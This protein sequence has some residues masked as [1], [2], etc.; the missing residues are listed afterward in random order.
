MKYWDNT[1]PARTL[2]GES[3]SNFAYL[4]PFVKKKGVTISREQQI[5]E[6]VF[7]CVPERKQFVI[8]FSDHSVGFK[9]IQYAVR[10]YISIKQLADDKSLKLP[11]K[12]LDNK[13]EFIYSGPSILWS[14][15]MS[16]YSGCIQEVAVHGRGFKL[17]L[18]ENVSMSNGHKQ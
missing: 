7:L 1:A 4:Q 2:Y 3:A 6:G 16:Q 11:W 14:P 9:H 10:V 13:F 12:I 18:I 15:K 8:T 5:R 17:N